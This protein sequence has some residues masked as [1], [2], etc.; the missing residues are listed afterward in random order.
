MLKNET[1]TTSFLIFLWTMLVAIALLCR[2]LMPIDETRYVSV[3]W[4]MWHNGNFLVPHL[5]GIPYSHK[6]PLFFYLIHLGWLLFGVNEWSARLTGPVFGLFDLLIIAHL[7]RRLWPP[8]PRV[9]RL[10]PF[11]LLGL[12]LWAVMSTLTMFDLLL[13]FF[14]LLGAEGLLLSAGEKNRPGGWVLLGIAIGGGLLSKG[15][16]ALLILLPLGM[17]GPWWQE[18]G[19]RSPWNW[20]LGLTFSLF[21]GL[22][23]A[24]AWAIPAAKAGGPAYGRAILWGQTAGRA[25]KSFAH[26]RPSWWYLPIIPLVI[27]PW[28]GQLLRPARS[29]RMPMD[30]G[31]RFCLCWFFPALL[32]FSLVS[33]KQ[34]H[35]L[36]PLLPAAAL[37]LTRMMLSVNQPPAVT[38]LKTMAIIYLAAGI[39]L[40]ILPYT[41]SH[42]KNMALAEHHM[43]FWNFLFIFGG[44]ILLRQ[45]SAPVD[46]SIIGSCVA[47]VVFLS[48][49]HLGPFH[50][51]KTRYN[52]AP[53]ATKIAEQQQKGKKI[54]IYPAKFSNQFQFP[55]RLTA[56]LQAIDNYHALKNWLKK[57]P[58]AVAVMVPKMPLPTVPGMKPEY[59]HP[60]RGRQS[61][62]WKAEKLNF[63]LQKSLK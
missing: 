10:A 59:S 3:A 53:M 4:E 36:L 11:V 32:L 47:V 5:N 61:S 58:D 18:A 25:V 7:A 34:A 41:I 13:T 42:A 62:L 48:L 1:V 43:L 8:E 33:G 60:F 44:I 16:V 38:P 9:A 22:A 54:A 39:F 49:V 45:R 17:L 50:Q 24:L 21:I 27:L 30:G 35:Y 52:L 14:A 19:S 28:T 2:P 6:P 15:P 12:P 63:V 51:L 37:L 40:T 31:T 57:N 29:I 55:G 20:Y 26:R 56:P 46:A 23:I